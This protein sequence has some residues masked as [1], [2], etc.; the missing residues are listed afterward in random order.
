MDLYSEWK[1]QVKLIDNMKH[2]PAFRT[3]GGDPISDTQNLGATFF[4]T[5]GWR[6]RPF[7]G[8][9]TLTITGNLFTDP[10][11]DLIVVPTLGDFTVL[12]TMIVSNLVDSSVSRLDLTQ[13]L[14][15]VYIDTFNGSP[16]TG[17]DSG[18]PTNPV[19][20][21][22][23]AFTI[24]NRDGLREFRFR[25]SLLLDRNITDWTF[26]SIGGEANSSLDVNGFTIDRCQFT[27]LNVTGT[28]NGRVECS[29]C[30][31]SATTLMDGVFREC[32]LVSTFSIADNADCVFSDCYSQVPGTSTPICTA[33]LN[34]SINFRNYSGGIEIRS[35]TAGTN[36]SLDLDPGLA[37]LHSSNT[38]G[39]ILVRGT[40]DLTDNSAGSTIDRVG[41]IQ[42]SDMRLSRQMLTNKMIVDPVTGI[43]TLYDDD[44]V[45]FLTAN[46]WEDTAGTIGYRQ[47][48]IDRREKLT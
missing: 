43:L 8:D 28:M 9:H 3:V 1:E 11:G 22:A 38:G 25:G 20:N 47:V 21:I 10:A 32:G 40:G 18:T 26:I 7:E 14:P 44:D 15:A 13:L 39:V 48:G 29:R 41:L 23:D 24:A 37:V 35:V 17:L 12:V 4:L 33:G 36:V 46:V 45:A 5:N 30:A 16:G 19:N 34:S 6:I 2:P 31:L 42:G 27:G